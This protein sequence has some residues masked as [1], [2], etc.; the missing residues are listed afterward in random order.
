[1]DV[2]CVHCGR[3]IY[4]KP[5]EVFG[6]TMHSDCADEFI[7]E[8]E[9]HLEYCRMQHELEEESRERYANW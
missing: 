4:C 3:P 9:Q 1:M 8:W 5:V 2:I 6:A 7:A